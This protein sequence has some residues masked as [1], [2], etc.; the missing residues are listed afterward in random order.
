MT[1]TASSESADQSWRGKI[2]GMDPNEVTNF[3]SGRILARLAT[4]D[5][6]GFPYIVP[7]WFEWN[8]DDGTFW[9]IARKKSKWAYLMRQNPKVA[10]SIDEDESPLRKVAVQ[11]EAELVEEPN[12][13]GQWVAIAERMS[14]RY[15]GEHGPDYLVPTLDKPRW[16]FRIRPSSF[17]TWQGVDWHDRYKDPQ[18][19][20]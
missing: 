10:M 1:A 14:L 13:G 11:G 12:I 20:S 8:P 9:V 17:V 6:Q 18:S 19:N 2:G 16:L 4:I 5:E 3:L 15:L 7:I